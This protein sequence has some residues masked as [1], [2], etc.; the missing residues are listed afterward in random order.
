M[1]KCYQIQL[2]RL[3][4]NLLNNATNAIPLMGGFLSVQTFADGDWV[5]VEVKNTGEI[6][7]QERAGLLAGETRGRGGHITRRIIRMLNG[8]ID[9]RTSEKKTSVLL[10][11]PLYR[12]E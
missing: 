11:I 7:E 8:K 3:L 9:I 5:C 12:G 1:V 4:D 6:S 10:K 2:E